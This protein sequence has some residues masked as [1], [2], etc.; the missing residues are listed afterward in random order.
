MFWGRR[1]AWASQAISTSGTVIGYVSKTLGA[2]GIL[3]QVGGAANANN[4]SWGFNASLDGTSPANGSSLIAQS[5]GGL[6]NGGNSWVTVAWTNGAPDVPILYP[7]IRLV[8]FVATTNDV[9][10]VNAWPIYD[11]RNHPNLSGAPLQE[12]TELFT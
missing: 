1:Q 8:L 4:F 5:P 2:R 3:L 9:A 7:S 12:L 10:F 6:A 11:D